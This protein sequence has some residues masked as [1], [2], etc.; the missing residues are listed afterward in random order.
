MM[1][2]CLRAGAPDAPMAFE[3]LDMTRRVRI[4]HNNELVEHLTSCYAKIN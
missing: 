2:L 4:R 1:T 3:P